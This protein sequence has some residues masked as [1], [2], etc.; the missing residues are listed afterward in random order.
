[1]KKFLYILLIPLLISC[2][3][4]GEKN[5]D[6]ETTGGYS[7]LVQIP[8]DKYMEK[9]TKGYTDPELRSITEEAGE[10]GKT[11]PKDYFEEI[12]KLS[13]ERDYDIAKYLNKANSDRFDSNLK[14]DEVSE[15]LY[16]GYLD[17]LNS[18]RD[19]LSKR[20]ENINCKYNLFAVENGRFRVEFDNTIDRMQALNLV[21]SASQLEFYEVYSLSETMNAFLDIEDAIT[22][23]DTTTATI[24]VVEIPDDEELLNEPDTGTVEISEEE[25]QEQY[26]IASRLQFNI[27][28]NSDGTPSYDM[29]S[30]MI[31]FAMNSDTAYL[32]SIL[33]DPTYS[34]YLPKGAIVFWSDIIEDNGNRSELCGLYLFKVAN[35]AYRILPEDIEKA[36]AKPSELSTSSYNIAIYFAEEGVSKWSSLTATNVDKYVAMVL[37]DRLLSIPMV[38]QRIIGGECIISGNYSEEEAEE[39]AAAVNSSHLAYPLVVVE[40]TIY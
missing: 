23:R 11:K 21:F 29:S 38:Q 35:E 9:I 25:I 31:G 26:P 39:I 15:V 34:I 10:P 4:S 18:C 33:T 28:T 37:G 12:E 30:P 3:G 17:D 8:L 27:I 6:V 7:F 36:E 14:L 1:M 2:G 13:K 20:Y 24:E 22:G 32:N 5:F 16:D 40:E 19:D